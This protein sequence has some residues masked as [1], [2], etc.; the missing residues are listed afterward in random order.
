MTS[1]KPLTTGQQ[2]SLRPG[3][4]WS[5]LWHWLL[6]LAAPHFTCLSPQLSACRPHPV[7]YRNTGKCKANSNLGER[8]QHRFRG[9]GISR[10]PRQVPGRWSPSGPQQGPVCNLSLCHLCLPP[11]GPLVPAP[12]YHPVWFLLHLEDTGTF[13]LCQEILLS[14]VAGIWISLYTSTGVSPPLSKVS[15]TCGQPQS[16]DIK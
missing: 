11:H 15:V 10:V 16:G 2:A 1:L 13:C 4:V 8:G 9:Q 14:F 5:R 7:M 3:P 6:T 12:C